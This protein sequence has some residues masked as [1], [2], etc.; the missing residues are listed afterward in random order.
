MRTFEVIPAPHIKDPDDV[1]KIMR[2]VLISLIPVTVFSGF[3]FGWYAWVLALV[4]IFG[5][6]AIEYVIMR[7]F[8]KQKN[9]KSDGSASVTGLL[10][11]LNVSVKLPFWAF[12]IGLAFALIVGKHIYGGLGTNPFNPALVGRA[13]LLMSFPTA[14]TSWVKPSFPKFWLSPWD[15]QTT[16]TPLGILK[17][18]G[19]S[20]IHTGYLKLFF[21]NVGGSIGETSA[22][23]LILGFI[24]MLIRK[25][26]SLHIPLSYVGTVFVISSIFW[27]VNPEK[28][29]D[30]IFHILAGGLMLGALFMATD[31]VT[32]PITPKGK[33]I[34]G[35]GCGLITM[36]IRLM[37][38][39]PE[40]VSFSILIM[41]AFVPLIES[42]TRP[43]K[44]GYGGVKK[45]G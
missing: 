8:R 9:F 40:G 27:A 29:G 18:H 36:V 32:S 35:I 19:Y 11:A 20:A 14:M 45:N 22:F 6:E 26:V 41:N 28:Y 13:F 37:G 39:Y 34:F 31:M 21:G 23:L 2:D 15:V 1:Q 38:A 43:K 10:L 24:Y 17:E 7:L 44:F 25:R 16:A 33:V 5:G 4:G 3:I 12:L 30:P 42:A